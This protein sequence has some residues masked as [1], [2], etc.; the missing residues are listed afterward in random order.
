MHDNGPDHRTITQRA[1][2]MS[3]VG[4]CPESEDD[5]VA[6]ALVELDSR[7]AI[8]RTTSPMG[9]R[10]RAD[11][12]IMQTPTLRAAVDGTVDVLP[13]RERAA[14]RLDERGRAGRSSI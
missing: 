14:S 5:V 13:D 6:G 9:K 2:I 10:E 1:Q 12:P 7:I 11:H 3:W 8:Q 4:A